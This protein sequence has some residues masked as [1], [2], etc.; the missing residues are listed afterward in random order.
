[1]SGLAPVT[2]G[3]GCPGAGV[4]STVGEDGFKARAGLLMGR[5]WSG[6]SGYWALGVHGLGTVRCMCMGS[7]PGAC[8]WDGQGHL[9][10]GL[11][12]W[13]LKQPV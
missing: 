11:R 13:N 10:V 1:M 3:C 7:S 6:V 8:G 4:W 5:T 12:G 9:W 2:A